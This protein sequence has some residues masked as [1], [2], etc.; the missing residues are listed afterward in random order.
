M[1]IRCIQLYTTDSLITVSLKFKT[2]QHI[3]LK[4]EIVVPLIRDR[5]RFNQ[6]SEK[7]VKTVDFSYSNTATGT[8]TKSFKHGLINRN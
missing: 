2:T 5:N 4:F 1:T 8:E 7:Q 6:F 3:H